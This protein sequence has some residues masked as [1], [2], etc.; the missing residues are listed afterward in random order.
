MA[1]AAKPKFDEKGLSKGHL[2]KLT[3]LR[4]SVGQDI[5][6]KAFQ[7]WLKSQAKAPKVT[8]D[9]NAERITDTLNGLVKSSKLRIPR[10]GYLV[11]RGR[12]RVIVSRVKGG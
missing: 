4:K 8:V 5:G 6:T 11:T 12:G 1:K 3:A 2:R 7:D 9:K 10:G